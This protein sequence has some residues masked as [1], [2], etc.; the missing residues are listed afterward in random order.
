MHTHIVYNILS[1]Q[2]KPLCKTCFLSQVEELAAVL[3]KEVQR[4]REALAE[5][6]QEVEENYSQIDNL[7]LRLDQ[8]TNELADKARRLSEAADGMQRYCNTAEMLEK[9]LL[10][11]KKEVENRSHA[12]HEAQQVQKSAGYHSAIP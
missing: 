12:E 4:L 1:G 3:A 10:R 7:Q 5:K 8:T 9:Q 11:S 2:I 6:E